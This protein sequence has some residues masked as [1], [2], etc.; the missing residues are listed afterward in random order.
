MR[1]SDKSDLGKLIDLSKTKVDE[2]VMNDLSHGPGFSE[3][4]MTFSFPKVNI[5]K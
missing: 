3:N 5:H 2:I 1:L 4:P